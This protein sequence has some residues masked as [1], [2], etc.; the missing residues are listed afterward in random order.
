MKIIKG[1]ANAAEGAE[2]GVSITPDFVTVTRF[3]KSL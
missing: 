1:L 3:L 2:V